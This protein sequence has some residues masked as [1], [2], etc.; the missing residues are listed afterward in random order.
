MKATRKMRG[1]IRGR[2]GKIHWS[3]GKIWE[4]TYC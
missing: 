3:I 2:M 4:K 1:R